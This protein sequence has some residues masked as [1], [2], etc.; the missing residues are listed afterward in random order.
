MS[1]ALSAPQ[2]IKATYTIDT[3]VHGQDRFLPLQ[4]DP[5]YQIA[6]SKLKKLQKQQ[7]S[8]T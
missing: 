2:A 8:R 7:D 6:Y 1:D 3:I 4:M 5:E